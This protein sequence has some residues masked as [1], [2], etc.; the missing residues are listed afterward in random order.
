MGTYAGYFNGSNNYINIGDPIAYGSGLS[1][2]SM[3][4]WAELNS[5]PGS[6]AWILAIGTASAGSAMFIGA[7][8]NGLDGGAYTN[9]IGVS[10][11]WTAGVWNFVCLTYDGAT[12]SL[13]ANGSLVASAAKTWSLVPNVGYIGKQ[14][15]NNEPWPGLIDDARI[16]SR[17][18]SPAEVKA[19]YNL[20]K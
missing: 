20:E 10:N 18:L 3:C 19:L 16:Y 13:Y 6:Y 4:A 5:I 8:T 7:S 15:N 2:R 1:P 17:V 14:V 11:F 12:A 9:D